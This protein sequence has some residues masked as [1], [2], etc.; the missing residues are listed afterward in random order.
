VERAAVVTLS[1]GGP[2]GYLL[3]LRHPDRVSALLAIS[4]VTG[5]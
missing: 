1:A 2:P 3:A 5:R 4:S